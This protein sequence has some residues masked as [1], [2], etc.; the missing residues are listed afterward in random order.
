MKEDLLYQIALTYIHQIGPVNAKILIS[1]CGSAKSVFQ[2]SKEK[3]EKIPGIGP[4]KVLNIFQKHL[5]PSAE[6][7]YNYIIKH[8][9]E[10]ISFL[11]VNYPQRL[12]NQEDAPVLLFKKGN[13]NLNPP[14]TVGIIGTRSPTENGKIIT[15]KIIN[16]LAPFNV[17]IISGLAYGIDACAHKASLDAQI[18]TIGLLGNGLDKVYPS[19]HR[20]LQAKIVEHDGALVT[21]FNYET[22]PD[23]QNFPMR[24][25]LIAGMSDALIVIESKEKGGSIITAEYANEYNKDVFA[26]P[27]RTTDEYS[28]GCNGLIKK[29]K[30]YLLES[31]KDLLYIMRW[32]DTPKNKPVQTSLFLDLTEQEKIVYEF[33]VRAKESHIDD[34]AYQL[35]MPIGSISSLLLTLEFKGTIVSLPGKRYRLI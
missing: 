18:P 25:R 8:G 19:E 6:K 4:Q 35:Q 21:E 10:A 7:E 3:L 23:R 13:A 24:N 26:V 20:G 2:T 1:Y 28:A 12:K 32:D 14:R 31:T 30:A 15:Q 33:I 17:T 22:G 16:H 34:M 27:G 9:I 5:L 11:D 29:H